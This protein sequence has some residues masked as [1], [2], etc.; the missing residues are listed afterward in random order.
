MAGST[1]S[2][3]IPAALQHIFV[4]SQKGEDVQKISAPTNGMGFKIFRRGWGKKQKK[5]RV[6]KAPTTSSLSSERSGSRDTAAD[7]SR[8]AIKEKNAKSVIDA[9]SPQAYLDR[10]IE[11]RGYSVKKY[12]SLEGGYYCRPTP[13]QQ[14][15][16]GSRISFAVRSSEVSLVRRL[17]D[18][19]LSPNPCNNYG[20]SLVH[21]VCR[22]GDHKLL[23]VLLEAGCSLQVTDDYGR[24][25]L[26]DACWR[27]D[28]SFETVQLILDSDKHLL[29]LLDCR[30]AAPLSYVKKE[31][32]K[33]WIA[34][35]E[36]K[37]D[38][39]WPIR[40]IRTEGEERPPPLTLRSPHSIPIPDPVHALPLEVAAMVANGRMEP[41]E[42]IYLDDED[43]SESDDSDSDSEFD[44]DDSDDD[45][46]MSSEGTD[47]DQEEFAEICL[48][49]GG[50]MAIA[51]KCFGGNVQVVGG[52][53]RKMA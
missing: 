15:S 34:F 26:H 16:Y 4:A 25:P 8:K 41:E 19:G 43:D 7:A 44:S 17:L 40:D 21:M 6:V 22:R 10:Q 20:E 23:R 49:A 36:T 31:N 29:H 39:F 42:A 28:P 48:R 50:P 12:V 52:I 53:P 14:A 38:R 2:P 46:S 33:M 1:A 3:R 30:G 9:Q 18:A 24:T 32:Y 27:A 5:S 13:L 45:S 51:K 37:L 35:L 47:F 11:A